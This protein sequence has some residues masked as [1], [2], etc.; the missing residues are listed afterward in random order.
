MPLS[1]KK[2]KLLIIKWWCKRLLATFNIRVLT[3]GHVPLKNATFKKTMI[4]ANHISWT[5]IHAL[6]SLVAL[7]FVAKAEIKDWP[8]FGFL[9]RGANTLFIER[10]KRQ[11]AGRIVNVA[12]LSLM[13]GDNLCFFPEGT[14]TDGTEIKP[15]K[16]SLM[17]AAI[18]ANATIQ[19][20]AIRYPRLNGSINTGIAYA[21]ETTM[22]ESMQQI[23]F[24][25]NPLVELHFFEPIHVEGLSETNKDR[26]ALTLQIQHQIQQKLDL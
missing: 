3:T 10:G 20:V 12:A 25:K 24:Q 13:D 5:D 4:V 7:R 18:E 14:T 1:T 2:I 23:L 22:L 6:N 16:S 11:D 9:M 8:V 17:Q 21:G 26:R 19:P 15:F